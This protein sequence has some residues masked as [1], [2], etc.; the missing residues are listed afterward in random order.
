MPSVA[1][2]AAATG[3]VCQQ[4]FADQRW[5]CS[6]VQLAPSF[7]PDLT[8]GTVSQSISHLSV[9]ASKMTVTKVSV[10]DQQGSESAHSDPKP[11]LTALKNTQNTNSEK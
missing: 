11:N 1:R 6:S 5:N 8:G 2:A 7:A 4:L 3:R 10:Q 9:K